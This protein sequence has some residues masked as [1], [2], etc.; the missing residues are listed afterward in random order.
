MPAR[1][2][3]A[4]ALLVAAV[5]VAPMVA[6]ASASP[7]AAAAAGDTSPSLQWRRCG[8]AQCATLPVPLDDTNP[9][10]RLIDLALVRIRATDRSRRIGALVVN[11][12]GPGVP[13]V[14]F[15]RQFASVLPDAIRSRF[16]IVGFDPRGVGRSTH[17]DCTDN[18]EQYWNL[19]FAASTPESR[20]AL[21]AGV[22]QFVAACEARS[23]DLLPYLSTERTVRDL[24]RVRSALKEPKISFLGFSY[25]TL[26]GARYADRFPHRVRAAVLDGAID[27]KLSAEATAL[28]QAVGFERG[29][30][31]F[32]A[33]CSA[34]RSCRFRR[35]GRSAAAY[36]RLR[37]RLD[38]QPIAV[39]DSDR[40]R[41]LGPTGFDIGVT[42]TLYEGRD[43]WASL[44]EAL[45]AADRGDGE[46]L[47]SSFDTYTGRRANGR[48]DD[49]Q[50]AFLAISCLD[51]P[52]PG[53]VDAMMA[54]ADRAA[55][56]APRLGRSI[57]NNSLACAFW[58]VVSHDT[59]LAVPKAQHAPAI[60]VI[61]T[62]HD[63]ATPL[64]WAQGLVREL[65]S[66]VLITARGERHTAFR[67]GNECVDHA[68]V[69]YLVDLSVPKPNL[70]C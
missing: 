69:H 28:Q 35:N 4:V 61:G 65:A 56:V 10:S 15:V 48:Y 43:G 8:N 27:P 25:G 52:V 53:G 46:E 47:L 7:V 41:L 60:V 20:A 18:L 45:D 33:W 36:D 68:V 34:T 49:I 62:R 6:V 13:A 2:R 31:D 39:K 70:E 51:A 9:T 17:V 63:P 24:D 22:R 26:L 23:A 3:R 32:L 12:G 5:V 64:A 29:L 55:V 67:A 42:Q 58:P 14:S 59:P 37:A 21:V 40:S 30:D 66:G 57:I 1:L 38:R 44:G 54:I 11:P 16:D 19:D 50:E